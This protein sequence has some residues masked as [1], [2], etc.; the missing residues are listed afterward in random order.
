M[1][2]HSD[3]EVLAG[4]RV[5]EL[6]R[7]VAELSWARRLP[8]YQAAAV[9]TVMTPSSPEIVGL[10]LAGTQTVAP[11]LVYRLYRSVPPPAMLTWVGKETVTGSSTGA[12]HR[13]ISADFDPLEEVVREAGA[14]TAPTRS[15]VPRRVLPEVE[16]L[17]GEIDAPS[18]GFA[19]IAIPWHPDLIVEMDGREV[20]AELVN[21]AFT[22]VPVPEGLHEVRVFFASRAVMWGGVLSVLSV[23]LWVAIA[24]WM[25][26]HPVSRIR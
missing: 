6:A 21:F 2:Y 17:N 22:G 10:E 15:I 8:F 13:M 7:V 5:A 20:P 24:A 1:V 3:A 12:L 11:N 23:L 9:G 14:P 18:P 4:E 26:K 25:Y 16:I 19:V